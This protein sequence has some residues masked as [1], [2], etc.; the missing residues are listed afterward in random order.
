MCAK[1]MSCYPLLHVLLRVFVRCIDNA[2]KVQDMVMF[3]V[4]LRPLHINLY[5]FASICLMWK[6]SEP[7]NN[8]VWS[9]VLKG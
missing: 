8:G 7:K 3:R 6:M 2:G 5:Y 4:K 1:S 9:Y